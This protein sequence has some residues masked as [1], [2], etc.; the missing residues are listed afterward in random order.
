[1]RCLGQRRAHTV[2]PVSESTNKPRGP[3]RATVT[4]MTMFAIAA[5][6]VVGAGIEINRFLDAALDQ[7]VVSYD[8]DPAASAEAAARAN[9]AL[10]LLGTDM[11]VGFALIAVVAA[12]RRER[13][14]SRVCTAVSV[15]CVLLG[16]CGIAIWSGR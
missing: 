15:A 5:A 14:L 16:C 1:M 3:A 6:T 8:N 10:A 13:G 9:H 4:I 2:T 12:I 11:A 7:W